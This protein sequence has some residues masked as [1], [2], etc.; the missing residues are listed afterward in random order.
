MQEN[1]VNI[2]RSIRWL[3]HSCKDFNIKLKLQVLIGPHSA[4]QPTFDNNFPWSLGYFTPGLF[5]ASLRRPG[6]SN[7]H[8]FSW[9][10]FTIWSSRVSDIYFLC[11]E[12]FTKWSWYR[13]CFIFNYNLKGRTEIEYEKKA[14]FLKGNKYIGI[15]ILEWFW[16]MSVTNN[17][18]IYLQ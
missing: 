5:A 18:Y 2:W 17:M 14:R 7:L 15:K 8:T 4:I 13:N 3:K 1:K 9:Y 16:D 10:L 12:K 6:I 11:P